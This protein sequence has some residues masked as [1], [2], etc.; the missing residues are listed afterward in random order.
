MGL[1]QNCS[2]TQRPQQAHKQQIISFVHFVFVVS[3][4]ETNSCETAP[5]FIQNTG[6][7]TQQS[8]LKIYI[9]L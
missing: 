3:L 6:N 1:F 7:N 5:F 9:T 4:C 8:Q 2:F